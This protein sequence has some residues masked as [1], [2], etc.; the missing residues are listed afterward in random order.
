MV[1]ISQEGGIQLLY[2]FL[3]I[4]PRIFDVVPLSEY[5]MNKLRE[6]FFTDSNSGDLTC[7]SYASCKCHHKRKVQDD[8]A[9]SDKR[10]SIECQIQ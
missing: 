7:R 6:K 8:A 10:V 2:V 1:T 5:S 3:Q 4:P 9:R